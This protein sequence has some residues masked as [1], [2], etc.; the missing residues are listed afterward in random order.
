[1]T[2]FIILCEDIDQDRFI[3][4]YLNLRGVDKRKIRN[5]PNVKG[6]KVENNNAKVLAYYAQLV[7]SYRRL[8]NSQDI[9][10]IAMVDADNQSLEHRLRSFNM[11]L[12]EEEGKRN[13]DLRQP[14]EKIAIFIPARNIETWFE[15]ILENS[16]CNEEE[17]YKNNRLS[18]QER[19]KIA[20]QAAEIAVKTLCPQRLAD[21]GLP[22]LHHACRELARLRL[23]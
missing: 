20:E 12:D 22:S 16:D 2:K 6:L 1:M 3:R 11:A 7:K 4:K 15:Y 19:I 5:F 23:S 21:S 17:D 9:A 13:K 18:D 8:K 10:V 14:D